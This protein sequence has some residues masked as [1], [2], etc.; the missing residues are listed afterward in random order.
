MKPI[1]IL[2]WCGVIAAVA[3]TA[4]I[5]AGSVVGVLRVIRQHKREKRGP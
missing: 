4:V 2:I 5:A 3:L 1:D